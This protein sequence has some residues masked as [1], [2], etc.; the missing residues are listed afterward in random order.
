MCFKKFSV[1]MCS[2]ILFS[3]ISLLLAQSSAV[4]DKNIDPDQTVYRK[5]EN[6]A[7][8]VGES[9]SFAIRYGPIV[10]GTAIMTV[11][12]TTRINN[13]LCYHIV[14]E[15]R[16][17]NFVDTFFK[18]RDRAESYMDYEGLFTL[19]FEKQIREG[20]YERDRSIEYDHVNEIAIAG[21]D[22]MIVPRFVQDVLSTLYFLRTQ[23]YEIGDELSVQNHSDKNVYDLRVKI[24][25][26]EGVRVRA[27]TFKCLLVE[28]FLVEGGGIFKHEGRILVWITDDE[29][30][31]P[32]Q[33]KSKVY[34]GSV[35]AELEVMTG[36]RE[37]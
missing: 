19:K 30:H 5:I 17:N 37:L 13:R 34:I 35:T 15:A 18:V 25:G 10:A 24:H 16:S 31:I 20:K 36:V 27:G 33:M 28:P 23:D 4:I 1:I 7:W 14:T 32:V 29:R 6:N 11:K 8:D 3:M 26:K 22:T 12:D 21:K 9:L 2:G